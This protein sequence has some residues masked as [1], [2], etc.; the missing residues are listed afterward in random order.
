MLTFEHT[1]YLFPLLLTKMKK[2]ESELWKP[3]Q[4]AVLLLNC[5]W[6]FNEEFPYESTCTWPLQEEMKVL[7]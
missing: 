2:E 5:F 3:L 7:R 4:S 6:E 1:H